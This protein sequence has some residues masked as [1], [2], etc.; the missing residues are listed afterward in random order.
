ML[1]VNPD[2][3]F[4]QDVDRLK[5]LDGLPYETVFYIWSKMTQDC[6]Q[7]TKILA[8]PMLRQYLQQSHD[9]HVP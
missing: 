1:R 3:S 9:Q 4:E 8:Q 2:P 5:A 7:M 6:N